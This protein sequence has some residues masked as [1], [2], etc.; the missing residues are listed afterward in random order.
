MKTEIFGKNGEGKE[1]TRITLENKK[2]MKAGVINYGAI[3]VSLVVPDKN[4]KTEDVVL[5]YDTMEGYLT[6]SSFFGAT[7]GRNANRIA[8]AKFEIDGVT[9][10]LDANENGNNLHSS[11]TEGYHAKVWDF[12]CNEEKNEVTFSYVSPDLEQGFP[13]TLHISVTYRLTEENEL[14]IIYHGKSD[15]KTVVNLTNHS[16]FNLAGHAS[17]NILKHKLWLNA[18][19]FT[20]VVPGA[21]PTGEILTVEGTPMDFRTF[22]EVG[23]EIEEPFEQLTLTG[24]YDHNWALDT[25]VGKVEKIAEVKE[26]TSGRVMEVYTD[27]PG[28]QFYAGNFIADCIGKNK[29]AYTK[30]S[31]LCLETQYFPNAVNE[32]AFLSPVIE[33]GEEYK[34]TT[35]YKFI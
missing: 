23:K 11:F 6:N 21:I 1:I 32:P 15:K 33:A 18:S 28:V 22:K 7:V 10:Q 27:L 5:G 31:G 35:I 8:G 17:G 12:A 30:R 19:H 24:G 2:G 3:L 29:V 14:Q 20:P 4:G 34:T 25:E 9:Y 16:Y 26:E 13:G